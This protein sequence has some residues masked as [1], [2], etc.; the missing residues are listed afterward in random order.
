MAEG[1]DEDDLA[2]I[3][4]LVLESMRETLVKNIDPSKFL[5]YLRSKFVIDARESAII[6]SCCSKSVFDGAEKFID[7]LCTKG[8]KGYDCFCQYIIKDETQVHL[9]KALNKRLEREK[10]ARKVRRQQLDAM[11]RRLRQDPT[12]VVPTTGLRSQGL[13]GDQSAHTTSCIGYVPQDRYLRSRE[14]PNQVSTEYQLPADT[15]FSPSTTSPLQPF[16]TNSPL[17]TFPAN[18][19]LQSPLQ[20]SGSLGFDNQFPYQPRGAEVHVP[21]PWN[22]YKAV[23]P[24]DED[25]PCGQTMP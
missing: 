14:S 11:K 8:S 9:L 20:P 3:K 13:M 2:G 22:D 16:P 19:P 12:Q 18:S 15:C 23:P 24:Q 21:P 7:V 10:H 4:R 1:D 5:P 17:Q 25:G 6:K